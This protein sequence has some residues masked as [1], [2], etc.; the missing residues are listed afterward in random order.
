[1]NVTPMGT[2]AE[3]I[4]S[5]LNGSSFRQQVVSKVSMQSMVRRIGW[6]CGRLYDLLFENLEEKEPLV[7]LDYRAMSMRGR[8]LKTEVTKYA[9]NAIEAVYLNTVIPCREAETPAMALGVL[10][11][12]WTVREMVE[13][14]NA[15]VKVGPPRWPA[16]EVGNSAASVIVLGESMTV[17]RFAEL[18]RVSQQRMSDLLTTFTPEQILSKTI[19]RDGAMRAIREAKASKAKA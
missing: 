19:T 9:I 2:Q 17:T 12:P 10:K 7:R 16:D 5:F 13:L 8:M 15:E 1:M 4:E 6:G 18:T 3:C 11:Q 14:A